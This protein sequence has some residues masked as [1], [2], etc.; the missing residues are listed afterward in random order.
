MLVAKVRLVLER[1]RLATT[2]AFQS[3]PANGSHSASLAAVKRSGT[4][5][6]KWYEKYDLALSEAILATDLCRLT[7]RRLAL[8]R[9][10]FRAEALAM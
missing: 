7:L 10:F 3:L 9:R 6:T 1:Q 8:R 4:Y 5:L 2:F